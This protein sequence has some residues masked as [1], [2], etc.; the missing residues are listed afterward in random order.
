MSDPTA[1]ITKEQHADLLAQANAL[2]KSDLIPKEFQGKPSNV[3]MAL[4]YAYRLRMSPLAVM[5]GLYLVHGKAGW[6]SE[7]LLGRLTA[8]GLIKGTVR[9]EEKGEGDAFKVRALATE[10]E[11]EDV[12]PGSWVSMAMAQAEGWTKN[13]KYRTMPDVMLRKRAIAFLVR[14]YFPSVTMGLPMDD[15]LD[16]VFY[17]EQAR[18]RQAQQDAADAYNK[19]REVEVEESSE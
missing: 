8:S 16:D 7:F 9:Y 12:V 15:E 4:D 5:K 11:T 19:P 3:F 13:E 10:S 1:I 2:C 6:T 17:A 14:E 18:R